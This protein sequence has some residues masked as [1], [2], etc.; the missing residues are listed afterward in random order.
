MQALPNKWQVLVII[1]LFSILTIEAM[2]A[3]DR[4][5]SDENQLLLNPKFQEL[6]HWNSS[7]QGTTE[8]SNS[9]L[10]LK[11]TSTEQKQEVRQRLYLSPGH[12]KISA[13]LFST[14]VKKKTSYEIPPVSMGLITSDFNGNR[15][16]RIGTINLEQQNSWLPQSKIVTIKTDTE[17]VQFQLRLRKAHGEVR[18]RNPVVSKLKERTYFRWLKAILIGLLAILTAGILYGLIRGAKLTQ[19]KNTQSVWT[20]YLP[21]FLIMPTVVLGAILPSDLVSP[22]LGWMAAIPSEN[23]LLEQT[24]SDLAHFFIFGLLG[25]VVGCNYQSIGTFFPFCFFCTMS[26][27]TES[28][29]TFTNNRTATY[30]DVLIDITGIVTGLVLGFLF[31]KF[32]YSSYSKLRSLL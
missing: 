4:F 13:D 1:S 17:S 21:V 3:T 2:R 9:E 18:M 31:S 27:F 29:Q 23:I 30:Y 19:I 8:A 16:G 14:L 7:G 32:L 11:T 12:Y 28:I 25:F 10:V 5:H 22:L 24:K 26:L 20:L 15:T 6:H